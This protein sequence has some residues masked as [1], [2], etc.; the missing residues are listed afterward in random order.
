MSSKPA[1]NGGVVVVHFADEP[2]AAPDIF[3]QRIGRCGPMST[4]F[5]YAVSEHDRSVGRLQQGSSN[6]RF[7]SFEEFAQ[8]R[9]AAVGCE[10]PEQDEPEVAVNRLSARRAFERKAADV[11]LE[12]PAAGWGRVDQPGRE[13]AR[14]LE[15][16]LHG[17]GL[18]IAAAPLAE[19][20]HQRLGNIPRCRS[21]G[22]PSKPWSWPSASSAR[23]GRRWCWS[24]QV[25]CRRTPA[26]PMRHATACRCCHRFRRPPRGKPGERSRGG[27]ACG[28]RPP[29]CVNAARPT[30]ARYLVPRLGPVS[31][32]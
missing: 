20:V 13:P 5:R 25:S 6:P 12:L 32:S 28:R 3:W 31:P 17:R 11:V 15:Q 7:D 4:P 1:E 26:C 16:V 9:P 27:G 10:K 2:A 22:S 29:Y 21:P 14:V 18:A 30:C 8:R 19:R 24:S 23:R